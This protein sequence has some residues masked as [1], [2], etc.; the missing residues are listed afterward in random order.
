MYLIVQRVP[1]PCCYLV[2][3]TGYVLVPFLFT[4]LDDLLS[5]THEQPVRGPVDLIR[6]GFTTYTA[7]Y[8]SRLYCKIVSVSI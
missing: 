7:F 6:T 3:W 4:F 8:L 2:H 5:L 1:F